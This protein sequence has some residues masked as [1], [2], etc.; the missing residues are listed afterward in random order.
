MVLLRFVKQMILPII[1]N[2]AITKLKFKAAFALEYFCIFSLPYIYT[3]FNTSFPSMYLDKFSII[4]SV[5]LVLMCGLAAEQC[6][7]KY[8]FSNSQSLLS[9]GSGSGEHTSKP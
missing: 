4:I 1:K 9:A 3:I 5:S 7:V 6:G 8:T 2:I